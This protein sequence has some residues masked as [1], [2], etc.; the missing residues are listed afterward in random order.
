MTFARRIG[1]P[2]LFLS[3]ADYLRSLEALGEYVRS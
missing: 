2:A 1:L 3:G